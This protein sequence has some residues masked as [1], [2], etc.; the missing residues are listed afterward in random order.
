MLVSRVGVKL[1]EC[2]LLLKLAVFTVGTKRNTVSRRVTLIL[3]KYST[4]TCNRK[5]ERILTTVESNLDYLNFDYL[6]TQVLISECVRLLPASSDHQ[7][8]TVLVKVS[9]YL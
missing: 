4:T 3:T 9:P 5:W 2:H 1:D 6:N 7:G 8:W